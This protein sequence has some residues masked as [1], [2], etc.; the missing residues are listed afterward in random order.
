[1]LVVTGKGGPGDDGRRGV[2]RQSVPHWLATEEL[3]QFVV[4][5]GEAERRHGGAGALYVRIRRRAD[6][7]RRSGRG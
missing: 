4:G 7:R 3:R 6:G 5:F 1:V 2:L